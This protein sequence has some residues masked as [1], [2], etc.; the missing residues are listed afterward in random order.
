MTEPAGDAS[1]WPAPQ[2]SPMSSEASLDGI[3]GRPTRRWAPP[4]ES[5]LMRARRLARFTPLIEAWSSAGPERPALTVTERDLLTAVQLVVRQSSDLL[6]RMPGGL[7]RIPLLA[8]AMIAAETLDIPTSELDRLSGETPPP[9]P[10]ALITSRMVRRRELE[11]LD[12][13]SVPVASAL[14]PH[15]LRGD[16]LASAVHGG[17]ALAV[18]GAMRLLFVAPT[19]GFPVVLGVPPRVVVIDAASE[20]ECD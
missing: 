7:Q 1:A 17:R 9:G 3:G 19:T 15:R 13:S 18:T 20:V 10:V 6:I 2:L 4:P 11:H 8:A 12:A 14:H 5:A 16:G